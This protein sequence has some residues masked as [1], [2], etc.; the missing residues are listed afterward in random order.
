M[1]AMLGLAV[2]ETLDSKINSKMEAMFGLEGG[3][4]VDLKKMERQLG[5][6][7]SAVPDAALRN[8]PIQVVGQGTIA[9]DNAIRR[10][11]F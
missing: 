2:G 1:D 5:D 6:L 10:A 11:A 4:R 9:E 8:L 7:E 3:E